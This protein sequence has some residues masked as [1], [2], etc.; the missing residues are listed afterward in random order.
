MASALL[1]TAAYLRNRAANRRADQRK[2]EGLSDCK[3]ST[4]GIRSAQQAGKGLDPS[5][6]ANKH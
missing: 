1:S 6:P 5:Q 4:A 3:R 2:P